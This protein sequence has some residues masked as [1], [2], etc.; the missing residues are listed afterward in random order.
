MFTFMNSVSNK[1]SLTDTCLM[2]I[3]FN[4][5]LLHSLYWRFICQLHNCSILICI[6]IISCVGGRHNMPPPPASW[7]L[8]FWP[9]K[10]C[11]SHV[12]YLCA[13]FSLPRPL[14][15]RLR[16]DVVNVLLIIAGS[17]DEL[18]V[19]ITQCISNRFPT[20][21]AGDVLSE[22]VGFD[23][24]HVPHA[25]GHF[26]GEHTGTAFP[27]LKCLRTHRTHLKLRISI[28]TVLDSYLMP[29]QES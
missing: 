13:N 14:C 20:M 9:W 2:M 28:K 15:S 18:R 8:T 22:Y 5:C 19:N 10:W 24:L 17:F 7:P 1:T 12:G 16:P 23:C 26:Q 6:C 11:P 21:C 27:L 29:N 25:R 3:S 4:C